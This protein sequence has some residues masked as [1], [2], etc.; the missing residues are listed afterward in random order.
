MS[1]LLPVTRSVVTVHRSAIRKTALCRKFQA[2]PDCLVYLVHH[3]PVNMGHIFFEP[4]FV[5]RAD[6]L[7][8]DHRVFYNPVIPCADFDMGR[9]LRLIHPGCN[10]RTDHRRAVPVAHIVLNDQHRAH[11]ALF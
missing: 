5:D 1:E 2:H 11:P 9:Q 6:L 4:L 8:K 10:C 3:G 7:Q